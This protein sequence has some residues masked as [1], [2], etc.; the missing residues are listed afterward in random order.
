VVPHGKARIR[1]QMNAAHSL[2]ELDRAIAAFAE[3]GRA[4]GLVR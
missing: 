3:A 2:A 4:L 1:T